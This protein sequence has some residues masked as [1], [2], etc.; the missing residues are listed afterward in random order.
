MQHF[1]KM[2]NTIDQ[3][4]AIKIEDYAYDLPEE[5][6]AKYPLNKR[7]D[8]KLLIYDGEIRHKRFNDL[9]DLLNSEYALVFN[10]TRVIQARLLFKKESGASIEIFCLEPYLPSDYQLNFQSTSSCQ[11][12]CIVGN[13][14]KWKSGALKTSIEVRGNSIELFAEKQHQLDTGLVVSFHWKNESVSFSEI[15]E[16]FGNTPIPPYLNRNTEEIDKTR[17]QT[18]YSKP[19]G[20]VAAPT[21]GL[22]FTNEILHAL[23]EK[24]I[25]I[26]E[27]TLHVGAGTFVPVK[28][29]N[30]AEHSM[31]TE[32]IIIQKML[33]EGLLKENKKIVAVGT[34]SVRT[35]ESMYWMG[36]KCLKNKDIGSEDLS[37][38][39][40]EAYQN[41]SEIPWQMS[42]Q[43]LLNFMK[44]HNLEE[45]K[46][47]TQI[48]IAP[49]Y[50]PRVVHAL[51]TNFHQPKST[52]LLLIGAFVGE[53]WKKIY[54]Y[55][56]NNEFRFLSYGDSSILFH[57]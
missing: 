1:T 8:S 51:I 38:N 30:I 46:S 13:L 16:Q 15:L 26:F 19:K 28:A 25:P 9:P 6:I 29:S 57:S 34:T 2:M 17:Y 5:R 56:L 50:K 55:A 21:A 52:L 43:T 42:F 35:L 18:V 11:W 49:G 31:H 22:H 23:K 12:K 36:V 24:Q 53:K 41:P 44:T 7:D 27:T 10:N 37:I 54:A 48:M 20:S 45:I 40:W 33:L 3:I 32:H 39:Q 4:H 47:T 14:R